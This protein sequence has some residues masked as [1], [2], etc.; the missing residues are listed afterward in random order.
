[1]MSN[2]LFKGKDDREIVIMLRQHVDIY[3][4]KS[5]TLTKSISNK[6]LKTILYCHFEVYNNNRHTDIMYATIMTIIE[7]FV[8]H[9]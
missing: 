9:Y 7:T 8:F 5:F 4:K 1:M 2:V 3:K 6:H